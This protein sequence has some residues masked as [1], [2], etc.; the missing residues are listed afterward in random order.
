MVILVPISIIVATLICVIIAMLL[1]TLVNSITRI[2][3]T[4]KQLIILVAGKEAKPEA[5]RAL[6]ASNKPPQGKLKG[7]ATG[8][9]KKDAKK[10]T[11]TDYIL[12]IGDNHRI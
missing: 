10:P 1:G 2:S 3:E 8:E 5:L 11:N 7:I 6:A 4:N 12:S 9:K